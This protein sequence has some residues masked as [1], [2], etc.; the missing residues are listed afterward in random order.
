MS[1]PLYFTFSP[2]EAAVAS[3]SDHPAAFLGYRLA[4]DAPALLAPQPEPDRTC[5]M[6]LQ[7]SNL[8]RYAPTEALARLTAQ[9][10]ASCH[11][12]LIC[13]FAQSPAPFWQ[14]FLPMLE[15][16]CRDAGLPLWVPESYGEWAPDSAVM[17]PSDCVEGH[18]QVRLEKAIAGRS[19]GCILELHPLSCRFSLPCPSGPLPVRPEEIST[20]RDHCL[21]SGFSEAL[22]CNWGLLDTDPVTI[23][24]WDD[25]PS[26]QR[27]LQ[28]AEEAG[29]Q[30]AVGLFQELAPFF[31][32]GS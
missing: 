23:L 19:H 11:S 21:Q 29:F 26:L 14:Q 2:E 17:I 7:D 22:C 8:P 15:G 4:A 25:G 5:R 31:P 6:V 24:L 12:G 30:A 13:D 27:K 16:A 28:L 10:A 3:R 1:L 9:Y 20:L 18:F 32:S